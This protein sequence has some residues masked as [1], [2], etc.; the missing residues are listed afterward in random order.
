V[1][2]RR[3]VA[4]VGASVEM[5]IKFVSSNPDVCIFSFN[6]YVRKFQALGFCC[7]EC[8]SIKPTLLCMV[9]LIVAM[10]RDYVSVELGL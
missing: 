10:R 6:E 5:E 9:I 2:C 8:T 3:H 4:S 1:F 7:T